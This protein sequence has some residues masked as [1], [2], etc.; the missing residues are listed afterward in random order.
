MRKYINYLA[1]LILIEVITGCVTEFIPDIGVDPDFYVVE[2][3]I[4]DQPG[5]HSVKVSHSVPLGDEAV[6]EPI[7]N[8]NVWISDDN[9]T[10]Y[11]M[12]EAVA[13]TYQAPV[14]F[15]GIPGR[16]YTLHVEVTRF[17]VFP[18]YRREVFHTLKSF[19]VEMYPVPD[20]DSLYYEKVELRTEDGFRFPGEG[21]QVL[22]NTTDPDAVC[23]YYRWDY[24]ETWKILAP[25]FPRSVNRLCWA[26]RESE[27]II[28]KA[29][30]SLNESRIER[31]P[32]KFI[33]N[34]SDRLL[35]RY[36][37]EVNQYSVGEDEFIYWSNLEKVM[38]QSGSL[39]D[40]LPAPI[41]G[42]MYCSDDPGLQILGYFSASSKRSKVIYID[43][44]FDHLVDPYSECARDT[45]FKDPEG[46]FPP[47][48]I[49]EADG[50][51]YWILEAELEQNPLYLIVTENR[52]CADC[53]V[54][55]TT[56]RPDYWED[57]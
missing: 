31:L 40:R 17:R 33:S 23:E 12:E 35:E 44:T 56:V 43:D 38:E 14:D 9:N 24:T 54:N 51:Y 6:Y 7:S 5:R 52:A 18:P 16:K 2:G 36:R 50:K 27:D 41:S 25:S 26:I 45:I 42:N 22:I 34:E 47:P 30:S 20:I 57:K 19:P 29:V 10:K 39:Y 53:T 15:S 3:L 8:C 13:G 28:V 1:I 21:C 11:V 48:G 46:P 37:I 55:G 49:F 32:V 4:T